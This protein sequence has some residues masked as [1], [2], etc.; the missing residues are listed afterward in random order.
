MAAPQVEPERLG[1]LDQT[2]DVGVTAKEI[3]DELPPRGL[4]LSDHLPPGVL[5]PIDKHLDGVVDHP[6]HGLGCAPHLLPLTG[7]PQDFRDVLPHPPRRREVQVHRL[8]RIDA[9]LGRASTKSSHSDELSLLRP[10]PRQCGISKDDQVLTE[11]FDRGAGIGSRRFGHDG[12]P[13]VQPFDSP[14]A[15]RAL[16]LGAVSR[17]VRWPS[18]LDRW[19]TGRYVSLSA[20]HAL[21]L[22][23][24]CPTFTLPTPGNEI[25]QNVADLARRRKRPIRA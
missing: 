15:A 23:P 2:G 10:T 25:G 4:L 22:S 3:V 21:F 16:I 9:L 6:Q 8:V 1:P 12:Q 17:V 13:V 7:S 11:Q 14:W 19:S 18:M 20:S 24:L 5:V